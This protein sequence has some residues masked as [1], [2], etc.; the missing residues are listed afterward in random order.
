[1]RTKR[2]FSSNVVGIALKGVGGI[3]F[4]EHC[5]EQIDDNVRGFLGRSTVV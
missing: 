4:D 5:N 1:M 3:L 2:S